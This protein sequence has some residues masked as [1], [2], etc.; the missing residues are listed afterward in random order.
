MPSDMDAEAKVVWRRVL[1]DMRHTG[2]IRSADAD[3][4]R[5][6]VPAYVLTMGETR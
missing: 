3:V 5:C 6:S 2:V 4:L 1:R